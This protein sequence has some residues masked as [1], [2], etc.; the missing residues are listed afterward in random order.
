MGRS[1]TAREGYA[2]SV[3]QGLHP[4]NYPLG[5]MPAPGRLGPHVPDPATAPAVQAAFR[6]RAKGW[7]L[8]RIR[9][10]LD[11]QGI[12]STRGK[13]LSRQ[14][15]QAILSNP[16]YAGV[17]RLNGRLYP[18]KHQPLISAGLFDSVSPTLAGKGDLSRSVAK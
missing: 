12:R 7:P 2:M 10:A 8:G 9:E 16:F 17:I 1:E 14:A 6:L 13:P 3:R 4:G 5:Y 15:L 18:G 11:A